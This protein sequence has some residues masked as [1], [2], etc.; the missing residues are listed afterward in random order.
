[1]R[2]RRCSPRCRRR[3]TARPRPSTSSPHSLAD[4]GPA[5]RLPTTNMPMTA[6]RSRR[7]PVIR[8]TPPLCPLIP[9][10]PYAR[11]ASTAIVNRR[12]AVARESRPR[13][14]PGFPQLIAFGA[15]TL[16]SADAGGPSPQTAAVRARATTRDGA[17]ATGSDRRISRSDRVRRRRRSRDALV[18][19]L[20]DRVRRPHRANLLE[21]AGVPAAPTSP[22]I[23]AAWCSTCACPA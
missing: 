1:M 11:D 12:S 5:S 21:R 6:S 19:A 4:A 18:A 9:Y 17:G 15:G 13:S 22:A 10:E 16:S 2:A 7:R 3:R 23:R 14:S 8:R 20:A